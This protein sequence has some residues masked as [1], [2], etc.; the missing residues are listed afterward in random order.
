MTRLQAATA[1]MLAVTLGATCAVGCT[2]SSAQPA[3]AAS[4]AP[5]TV[6]LA[7]PFLNNPWGQVGQ[8]LTVAYTKQLHVAA[9]T[10]QSQ[11][12]EQTADDIEQGRA[13]LAVDDAETAYIAYSKGTANV[14]EPHRS[15]RAISVLFST[16][17]QIVARGDAGISKVADLRGRRVDVGQRGTPTERAARLILESH[18]LSYDTIKPVFGSRNSIKALSSGELDARFYYTP[19]PQSSI[20]D[21]AESGVHLIPI[22]HSSLAAIQEQ[23]HFLKSVVIPAGTY[24]RQDQPILTVGMD[25]LLLCRQDLPEHL[26]H[27]MTATLFDSISDLRKAH[28]AASAIDPDRGPTTAVPLHAGAVRYYREREILK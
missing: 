19:Y 15:I 24:P 2:S 21:A 27:D 20:G 5:V 17:V 28:E 3:P 23:H 26:V 13:D 25:L 6:R 4:I 9:T 7:T 8:A 12:L 14:P 16:A 18:G 11:G 22:E 1:A 10:T